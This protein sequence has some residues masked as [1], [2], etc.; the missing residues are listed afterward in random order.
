M[1]KK[2]INA[3]TKFDISNILKVID[4]I[5]DHTYVSEEDFR[6]DFV[7]AI[8]QLYDGALVLCEY[9]RPIFND[10]IDIFIFYNQ[11]KY[12]IELKY[13]PNHKMFIYDNVLNKDFYIR[14]NG[15][16]VECA[17]FIDTINGYE[18]QILSSYH[19]DNYTIDFKKLNEI[20]NSNN[21]LADKYYSFILTN[22]DRFKDD[23]CFF[24]HPS[25]IKVYNSNSKYLKGF[26]YYVLDI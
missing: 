22:Y 9:S 4:E 14:K 3:V 6:I 21:F 12:A 18:Y 25:I 13:L 1:R 8:K 2:K 26:M 11:E 15:N 10:K 19:I 20:K 24:I 7:S 23:K 5:C 16:T 17:K